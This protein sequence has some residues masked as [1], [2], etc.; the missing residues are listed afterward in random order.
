MYISGGNGGDCLCYSTSCTLF[1]SAPGWTYT[2]WD[3]EVRREA[4]C[5][6]SSL[7]CMPISAMTDPS[8]PGHVMFSLIHAALPDPG[9]SERPHR[10]H[11]R[12]VQEQV[13]CPRGPAVRAQRQA[14]AA[15]RLLHRRRWRRQEAAQLHRLRPPRERARQRQC[16]V[17]IHARDPEA[18]AGVAQ[19]AGGAGERRPA[20]G[21]RAHAAVRQQE[22]H[23]A[24]QG[25]VCVCGRGGGKL[26]Q[27]VDDAQ[28]SSN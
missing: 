1:E 17:Q 26:D 21:A 9:R 12:L 18:Q 13:V 28:S 7:P 24:L 10:H 27:E 6:A 19:E 20:V 11:R 23:A 15:R 3:N 22:L 14:R 25:M 2:T 8:I 16:D 5:I 4:F